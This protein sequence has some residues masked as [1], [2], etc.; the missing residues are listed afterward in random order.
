M[1]L[2]MYQNLLPLDLKPDH[3]NI[4]LTHNNIALNYRR[5]GQ[6]K[7]AVNSFEQALIIWKKR[8]SENDLTV[9][10]RKYSEALDFYKKA[11]DIWKNSLPANHTCLDGV[12]NN[13]GNIHY[14]FRE[15]DLALENYEHYGTE[16]YTAC[17]RATTRFSKGRRY[18]SSY[19]TIDTF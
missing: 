10:D 8:Y 18:L 11:S 5:K 16:K 13:T 1:A 6:M 9:A 4:A 2:E 12:D 14:H 19:I 3:F 7:E 17:S 15:Y